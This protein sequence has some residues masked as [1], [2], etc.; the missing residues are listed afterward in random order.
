[1]NRKEVLDGLRQS[2]KVDVCV[3][4]GGINGLSVFASL[5]C[6]A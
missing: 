5:R 2:P 4:G 6:R 3:V 1:M